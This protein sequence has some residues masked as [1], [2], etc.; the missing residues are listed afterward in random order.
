MTKEDI[1][2]AIKHTEK[3]ATSLDIRR[4]KLKLQGVYTRSV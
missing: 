1:K 2:M 4:C 3:D